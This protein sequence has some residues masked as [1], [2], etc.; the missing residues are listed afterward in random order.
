[1]SSKYSKERG[2]LISLISDWAKEHD[3]QDSSRVLSITRDLRECANWNYWASIPADEILPLPK[4]KR[5]ARLQSLQKRFLFFRNLLI[6]LPVT[7]TWIAISE[8]SVSFSDYIEDNPGTLINFLQF[9]QNGYGYLGSVWRLSNIALIDFLILSAI[10]ILTVFIQ[11]LL[12]MVQKSESEELSN[13]SRDRDL[14]CAQLFDFFSRNQRITVLNM[15]ASITASL[16]DLTKST[17]NLEKVS[18]DLRAVM[19]EI[20]SLDRATVELKKVVKETRELK[21]RIAKGN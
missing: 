8:A 5:T 20:R 12:D 10:I 7:I 13:V 18:K 21:G 14:I 11:L 4:M 15:S 16:R 9:W 19:R 2:R 1:M 17:K 6:F 3:L